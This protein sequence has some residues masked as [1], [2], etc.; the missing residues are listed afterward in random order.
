[1]FRL[2]LVTWLLCA[3]QTFALMPLPMP[4]A[5]QVTQQ[6]QAFCA[7]PNTTDDQRAEIISRS[8]EDAAA[9]MGPEW[10]YGDPERMQISTGGIDV[11]VSV[12]ERRMRFIDPNGEP[13]VWLISPAGSGHVTVTGTFHGPYRV[14]NGDYRVQDPTKDYVGAPMP[15]AVFYAGINNPNLKELGGYAIH[16]TDYVGQLGYPASHGCVRVTRENAHFFNSMV[17]ANN[18]ASLQIHVFNSGAPPPNDGLLAQQRIPR[19]GSGYADQQ[20]PRPPMDILP[21]RQWQQP[22]L[23]QGWRGLFGN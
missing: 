7:N 8:L 1:M 13:H 2:G 9:C 20:P 18:N 11:E 16:G 22:S 14:E 10:V 19:A 12:S 17:R 5:A 15:W 3:S 21:Q 6:I 4:T 23:F